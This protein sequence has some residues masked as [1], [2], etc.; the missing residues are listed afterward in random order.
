[1][2]CLV[3]LWRPA[4]SQPLSGTELGCKVGLWRDSSPPLSLL[5]YPLT[6]LMPPDSLLQ[7]FWPPTANL[8]F[9]H[10]LFQRQTQLT[11]KSHYVAIGGRSTVCQAPSFPHEA[12]WGLL[13]AVRWQPR[14]PPCLFSP[15]GGHLYMFKTVFRDVIYS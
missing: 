10:C 1:M 9:P 2:T 8:M 13:E 7:R 3:T 15:L 4:A 5:L 12:P 14:S 11:T 6:P